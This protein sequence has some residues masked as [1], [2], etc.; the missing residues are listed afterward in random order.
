MPLLSRK[1]V[2]VIAVVTDIGCNARTKRVCAKALTTRHRLPARHLEPMLQALV[3]EGIL[4]GRRGPH[5]GYTLAR[6]P[7]QIT[8]VDILRASETRDDGM[9][10]SIPASALLCNVVSQ[11]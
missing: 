2:L 6:D 5:G 8:V 7:R 10:E 9:D 11:L 1:S 3:R 4:D